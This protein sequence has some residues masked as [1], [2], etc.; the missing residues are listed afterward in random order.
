M[1]LPHTRLSVPDGAFTAEADRLPAE[2]GWTGATLRLDG[3]AVAGIHTAADGLRLELA[4]DT[5]REVAQRFRDWVDRCRPAHEP[6]STDAVLSQLIAEA[7]VA[8]QMPGDAGHVLARM[9]DYR[10][11]FL[12]LDLLPIGALA[13]PDAAADVLP[14]LC[15]PDSWIVPASIEV[16]RAGQY[17]Q[18]LP[19]RA[20]H[21]AGTSLNDKLPGIL[22]DGV[23]A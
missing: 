1:E 23:A 13:S 15:G 20:G 17:W 3:A 5:D 18:M 7:C 11:R 9:L 12:R 16:Y 10:G 19:R 22:G 6:P 8:Y 4:A 21:L 2:P 14:G